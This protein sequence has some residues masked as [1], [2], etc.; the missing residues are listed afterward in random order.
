[1][2]K[3]KN[4]SKA[5]IHSRHQ[6]A[7]N[8]ARSDEKNPD[9]LWAMSHAP[10]V[11][12]DSHWFQV[13]IAA[14]F[15][16]VIMLV[17]RMAFYTA[18]LSGFYWASDKQ[19][20]SDVFSLVKSQ[21]IVAAAI[22]GV[23]V[24][25]YHLMFQ[26]LYVKRTY[27]YIPML[28]YVVFVLLSYAFSDYREFALWGWRDRFEGTIV[29]VAYMVMLFY[30]INTV[31]TEKNVKGILYT[32]AGTSS[33]MGL[34]GLSQYFRH[35]FFQTSI[36]GKLI[37][38][39]AHWDKLESLTFNFEEGQIYQTVFN[40]NYA[41]FYLTLLVPLFALL[42]I[43]ERRPA[44]R[45]VWA[46]LYGLLLFNLFGSASSGGFLG[47]GVSFIIA[48]T[49]LNKRLFKE[50]KYSVLILLAVSLAVGAFTFPRF[51]PEVSGAVK[52]VLNITDV[53]ETAIG[54]AENSD[55]EEVRK[56]DSPLIIDYFETYEDH[57]TVSIEGS[58][59]HIYPILEDNVMSLRVEDAQGLEVSVE[60]GEAANRVEITDP[61]FDR[62]SI[63]LEI[64][65]SKKYLVFLTDATIWPFAITDEGLLFQTTTGNLV[66]LDKVQA[67]GFEN[68]L[69]FGTYRGYI[70]S[71]S[72]PMIKDTL[73][74]GNGADTYC[75]YF[76][77]NDY[78]GRYSIGW[79]RHII[80]DKPH[81]WY[82]ATAINT[83]LVSLLALFAL[84]G[85]YFIGS[86]R[87]FLHR[88]YS[89]FLDYAG[90]G[91]FIGIC[92]FLAAALV[93]DSSVSVMPLFYGLLGT[94]IAI[95]MILRRQ[96]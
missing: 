51:L 8:P 36:G 17:V 87:L 86:L 62:C 95:N 26:M 58:E 83:G 3:N 64:N 47:L 91:I 25:L 4:Q 12:E 92:G 24:V 40:P 29:L 32:V 90:A 69:K 39:S 14:F 18:D 16:A 19:N 76:P 53:S 30:I 70:W 34:I 94:G 42:F 71:R 57:L 74:V 31:N 20:F 75:A 81:N 67:F 27:I 56:T 66:S 23:L 63:A 65:E 21:L 33:V 10:S 37:T 77:Q 60:K 80:V 15:T 11:G 89:I 85:I 48:V 96:I 61:R 79:N 22:L 50:W 72:L 49:L 52:G 1:M 7:K 73:L 82:I 68:N 9:C 93:N 44:V 2:A 54:T 45:A 43:Q 5:G 78:A 35:D 55:A 84:F 28:V 46:A 6:D 59:M 88:N 41:S 13:L 38:P